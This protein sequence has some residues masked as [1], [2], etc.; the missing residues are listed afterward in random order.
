[1]ELQPPKLVEVVEI[2]MSQDDEEL[3]KDPTH[4]L[5]I[6]VLEF[7]T[8]KKRKSTNFISLL[9]KKKRERVASLMLAPTT[10]LRVSTTFSRI[11]QLDMLPNPLS[12]QAK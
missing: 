9:K 7:K 5:H 10:F 3:T 11:E 8:Y 6:V 2:Y 12:I 1:M 4:C